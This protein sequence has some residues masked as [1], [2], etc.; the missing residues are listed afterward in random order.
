[1]NQDRC[2]FEITTATEKT[3][4]ISVFGDEHWTSDRVER[5]FKAYKAYSEKVHYRAKVVEIE[6]HKGTLLVVWDAC[7]RQWQIDLF[8]IAWREQGECN[9]EHQRLVDGKYQRCVDGKYLPV[10]VDQK[11]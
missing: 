9:L 8:E 1:M 6:D 10:E 11:P 3:G 4:R 7:P 5:C 2:G